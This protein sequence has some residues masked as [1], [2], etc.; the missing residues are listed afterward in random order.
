M[1]SKDTSRAKVAFFGAAIAIAFV[2]VSSTNAEAARRSCSY[3]EQVRILNSGA[4]CSAGSAMLCSDNG[5]YACCT[6][7]QLPDK[8]GDWGPSGVGTMTIVCDTATA[9]PRVLA[10]IE[11]PTRPQ[12]TTLGSTAAS[13]VSANTSTTPKPPSIPQ[14]TQRAVLN[15]CGGAVDASFKSKCEAHRDYQAV[16]LRLS[17]DGRCMEMCCKGH[18]TT[19]YTCTSDPNSIVD[20]RGTPLKNPLQDS[21]KR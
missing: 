16:N 2:F 1:Y 19:G 10:P 3:E 18:P 4:R 11:T 14:T 7:K 13:S 5:T 20:R 17:G 9:I 15:V 21:L 6:N 12:A 8:N